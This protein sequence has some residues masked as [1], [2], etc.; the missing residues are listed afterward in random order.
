[1]NQGKTLAF[2]LP[3]L[4]HIIK[5]RPVTGERVPL[6]LVLVPTRELAVQVGGEIMRFTRVC[7]LPLKASVFSPH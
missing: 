2:A 5:Q 1:M 3:A 4:E 6:A 7:S